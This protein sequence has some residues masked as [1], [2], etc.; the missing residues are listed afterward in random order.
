MYGLNHLTFGAVNSRLSSLSV[1]E[2]KELIGEVAFAIAGYAA[3][4]GKIE[5]P[6]K[7]QTYHDDYINNAGGDYEGEWGYNGGGCL[8]Y[9]DGGMDYY[10]DFGLFVKYLVMMSKEEFENRFLTEE[11]D[12]GTQYDSVSGNSVKGYPI[13]NKYEAVIEYFQNTLGIDLHEIGART[14]QLH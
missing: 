13:R 8:E 14:S 2:K 12:C 10:Y 6:E 4:K 3:S 5:V 7:F 1:E 9:R 11:F